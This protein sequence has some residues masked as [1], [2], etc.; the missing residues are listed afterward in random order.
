MISRC[1]CI[2]LKLNSAK[3]QLMHVQQFPL[4]PLPVEGIFLILRVSRNLTINES[5]E[6]RLP[7]A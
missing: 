6:S 4:E 5:L 1:F 3:G 7:Y 2:L